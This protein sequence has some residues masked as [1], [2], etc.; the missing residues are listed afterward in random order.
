[1]TTKLIS[2][3]ILLL[4]LVSA[5]SEKNEPETPVIDVSKQW[6][7]DPMGS[8][9]ASTGDEQWQSKTFTSQELDLF[10]SLDTA[11]LNGTTTPGSVLDTPPGYNLAYPNP[12][13]T[14][15]AIGIRLAP[16][17]AGQI[18]FKCVVVDSMM[19][20]RFKVATR[21]NVSGSSINIA[22]NPTIPAGRFRLYYTLSSQSN[23]H[24][25]KS[26]GNIQ[27]AL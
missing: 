7:I 20:S 17:S 8:V 9:I 1:M 26:W 16:G 27:K 2:S 3:C 21:Y 22:L 14:V 4:I 5:C 18:V 11:S 24:F 10:S 19:T 12:F 6:Y 15:N 25:Y 23:P 13:T